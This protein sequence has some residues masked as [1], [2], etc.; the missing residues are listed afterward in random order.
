MVAFVTETLGARRVG[1]IHDTD[2]FGSGGAAQVALELAERSMEPAL[3]LG[4]ET[5]T[6]DLDSVAQELAANDVDAVLIYGTN[7]TDV[8]RLLR[9][10]RYWNI[11]APIITSPG[12]ATVPAR[13]IAADAQD[14]IY[15]VTDAVLDET[16]EGT[17]FLEEFDARFGLEP[18][19]YITWTYDA[20]RLL[21][22]ALASAPAARGEALSDRIRATRFQGAQGEYRF[23]EAGDGL[24]SVTLA[25]M[26]TGAA[27]PLGVFQNG[28]LLLNE[29]G[30]EAGQE[31]FP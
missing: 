10:I 25:R 14:G 6:A 27:E 13:N 23:D 20:V 19:T 7:G 9:S 8:G 26:R 2:A 24:H 3:Q 1:I 16:A 4:Y 22:E 31:S 30:A 28:A 17:R 11:D 12:G 15:V 21:A 18:D 5:G 29:M